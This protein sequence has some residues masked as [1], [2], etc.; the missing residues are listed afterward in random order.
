MLGR[1]INSVFT[2]VFIMLILNLQFWLF[3]IM[4]LVVL[5]VGPALR[6]I[7]E[8]FAANEW[9]LGEYHFKDSWHLF[10]AHFW[11]ANGHF[12]LFGAVFGIL[13]Y[14]LYLS[15]QLKFGWMLF[16]QFIIMFAMLLCATS[17]LFT[18]SIESHYEISLKNAFRLA[19]AQFFQNFLQLLVYFGG[20][21]VIAILTAKAMGLIVFLSI[22]A[23]VVWTHMQSS[24]WYAQ[25]DAQLA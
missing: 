8:L 24:R 1:G 21:G 17:G 11:Q 25:I 4:G 5:G 22:A 2:K 14:S 23:V 16:I 18:L 10:K 6:T 15:T 7:T 3:T 20:L 12:W 9:Q 13:G 19:I